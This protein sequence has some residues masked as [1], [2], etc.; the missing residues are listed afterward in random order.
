MGTIRARSLNHAPKSFVQAENFSH[1]LSVNKS[2]EL[3]II[4]LPFGPKGRLVQR[5]CQ[6]KKVTSTSTAAARDTGSV[7]DAMV[8]RVDSK[9]INFGMII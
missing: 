1:R 4:Q 9:G 7:A 2:T 8:V 5:L 6:R 3:P